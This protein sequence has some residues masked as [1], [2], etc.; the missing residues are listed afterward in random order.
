[1]REGQAQ[2]ESRFQ[3]AG[4]GRQ[5]LVSRK[6]TCVGRTAQIQVLALTGQLCAFESAHNQGG[7]AHS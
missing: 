6:E 7:C 5:R 4:G 3:E 2:V 1:M